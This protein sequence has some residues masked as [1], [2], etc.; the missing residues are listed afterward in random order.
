LQTLIENFCLGTRR[1]HLFGT[2]SDS[3]RGWVTAGTD[4]LSVHIESSQANIEAFN[5]ETYPSSVHRAEDGRAI[6]PYEAEVDNLRPK[7]PVRKSRNL[8]GQNQRDNNIRNVRPNGPPRFNPQHAQQSP[9]SPPQMYGMGQPSYSQQQQQ[10][11]MPV[12]HGGYGQMSFGQQQQQQFDPSILAHAQAHAQAQMMQMQMMMQMQAQAQM[13]AQMQGMMM[14]N[15]GMGMG[16]GMQQGMGV[17]QSTQQGMGVNQGMGM[18][19]GMHQGMGA[20]QGMSMNG[21]GMSMAPGIG[22]GPGLAGANLGVTGMAP[23]VWQNQTISMGRQIAPA[24]MVPPARIEY[25]DQG[26]DE[27]MVESWQAGE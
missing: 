18:V 20:T 4:D 22:Q 5:A 19:M 27:E 11:Q 10:Q 14:G 3:R 12:Q 6:L 8:P 7:S 17:N 25:P 9:M 26:E 15:A 13:Q 21:M 16:M 2:P 24:P 23:G 1:L